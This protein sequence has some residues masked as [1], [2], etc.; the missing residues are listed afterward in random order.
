VEKTEDE[1]EDT[2]QIYK[3]NNGLEASVKQNKF[4]SFLKLTGKDKSEATLYRGNLYGAIKL[5]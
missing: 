3:Y 4:P 2:I 1:I 5:N